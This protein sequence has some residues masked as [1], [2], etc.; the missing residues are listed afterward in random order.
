MISEQ[1]PQQKKSGLRVSPS[2]FEK[3]LEYFSNNGWKFIKMSELDNYA[4]EN[5]IVAITFDDGYLDNYT[6]A[7]PLL[8]KYN[9]C[10][11]LYLVIDRHQ[12]DWSVK[13]NIK[14]N[15]GVLAAEE[16]LSNEHVQEMVDSDVFELGGHTITHPYL[17]NTLLKDKQ[18]E[19]LECKKMLETQFKTKISSFAYPF[20]IYDN[21]DV[22]IIKKG[23]YSSAVTTYEGVVDNNSAFELKRIKASG[24]DNFFA[25]KLRVL[26]GFR[27]FI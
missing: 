17:P 9:A 14:H 2:M 15:S 25:F 11:T 24:K 21:E 13:K 16:K 7:L 27:G 4:E 1:S 12:N 3:H 18:Y 10:A 5:K 22:N 19:M 6:K 8:K 23:N 26:K 20:G